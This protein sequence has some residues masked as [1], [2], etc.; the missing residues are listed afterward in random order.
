VAGGSTCLPLVFRRQPRLWR[1]C[2]VHIFCCVTCLRTAFVGCMGGWWLHLPIFDFQ[3]AIQAVTCLLC[4]CLLVCG[5]SCTAVVGCV[6]GWWLQLPDLRLDF[7]KRTQVTVGMVLYMPCVVAC[8]V[9]VWCLGG[10]WQHLPVLWLVFSTGLGSQRHCFVHAFRCAAS[11]AAVGGWLLHLPVLRRVSQL[12]GAS[13]VACG[14][15]EN[16]SDAMA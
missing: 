7:Q 14:C 1:A 13:A 9:V 8:P 11:A 2:S 16:G 6:G 3:N 15:W 4:T 5:V 10:W 12:D